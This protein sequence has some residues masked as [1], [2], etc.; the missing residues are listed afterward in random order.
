MNS[1]ELAASLGDSLRDT[2][3]I[4]VANREPCIHVRTAQSATGVWNWLHAVRQ[5]PGLEAV[6]G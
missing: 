2:R 3:L 6:R 1:V 4:V 5:K